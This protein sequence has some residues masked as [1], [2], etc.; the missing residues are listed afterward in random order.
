MEISKFC[1]FVHRTMAR[2]ERHIGTLMDR[3]SSYLLP[4]LEQEFRDLQRRV[5][6]TSSSKYPS[7]QETYQM[8]LILN[9]SQK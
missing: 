2:K 9:Y 6:Y 5:A 1:N 7:H 3:R 8:F 4:I